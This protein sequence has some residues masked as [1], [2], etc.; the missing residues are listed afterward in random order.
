[1]KSPVF[2]TLEDRRLLS[3]SITS[4]AA[5]SV[6][7]GVPADT[8][9]RGEKATLTAT[10]VAATALDKITGVTYFLD[11]NSNGALDKGEKIL[12]RSN[13]AAKSYAVNLL[14]K[15]KTALAPITVSAIATGKGKNNVS[16]AVT[17]VVTVVDDTPTVKRLVA[18]PKKV[19]VGG[20]LTL[21][22]T[23]A[24]DKDGTI[25]SVG[26]WLDVN[27]DG[28]IDGGDILEGTD[29]NKAG[30]FKFDA[31]ALTAGH[32]GGDT[33]TFLAQATDNDGSVSSATSPPSA[34]VTIK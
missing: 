11:T 6:V 17:D 3:V 2:E 28:Q 7:A 21:I 9:V 34:T 5:N 20:K 31:T 33:L 1:M 22:A 30:G 29:N 26:F 19:A 14:I 12:G 15:P 32:I 24:K 16:P 13:N 4:I 25:A 18:A 10:G 23:G 27:K 8:V